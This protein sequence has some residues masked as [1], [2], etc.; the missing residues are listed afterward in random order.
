[1]SIVLHTNSTQM[2]TNSTVGR[3]STN[4][5]SME[6]YT[7]RALNRKVAL[8][9]RMECNEYTSASTLDCYY[10]VILN[11]TFSNQFILTTIPLKNA[12]TLCGG[13]CDRPRGTNQLEVVVQRSNSYVKIF[14]QQT[15]AALSTTEHSIT[16]R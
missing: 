14:P 10:A 8:V 1:M 12:H 2:S 15:N 9:W 7:A 4:L 13:G 3:L 6:R 5:R 11:S 16:E